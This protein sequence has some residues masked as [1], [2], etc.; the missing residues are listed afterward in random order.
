MAE[1]LLFFLGRICQTFGSAWGVETPKKILVAPL[2]IRCNLDTIRGLTNEFYWDFLF[3]PNPVKIAAWS[4]Y[5]SWPSCKTNLLFSLLLFGSPKLLLSKVLISTVFEKKKTENSH[6]Q[7]CERSEL[8]S[9]LS[10]EKFIKNGQFFEFMI[11]KACGQTVS[12]DRSIWHK[13]VENA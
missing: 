7:H 2:R 6:I 4:Q 11:G 8:R 12:P 3:S 9:H 1:E 5:Y 10:W 13:L